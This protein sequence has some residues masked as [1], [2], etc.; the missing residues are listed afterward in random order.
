[1]SEPRD[2]Q[3]PQVLLVESQPV[4]ATSLAVELEAQGLQVAGPF[5][6]C[7][8]AMAW[9]A[10]SQPD[11]AI[12][13]VGLDHGCGFA[14]ARELRRRGIPFV[15]VSGAEAFEPEV[16]GEWGDAPWLGK[17]VASVHLVHILEGLPRSL[18]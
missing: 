12:V 2:G 9:L 10:R 16:L 4:A 7:R 15:I 6:G 14:L 1:M 3:R 11:R 13:D 17:P 8:E 5:S 18:S